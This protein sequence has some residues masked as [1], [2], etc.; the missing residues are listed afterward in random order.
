MAVSAHPSAELSSKARTAMRRP[1]GFVKRAG[2]IVYIVVLLEIV[3]P[4]LIVVFF[5]HLS[6]V[7]QFLVFERSHVPLP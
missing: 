4:N 1:S 3:Q 7:G 5:Y 6:S 2:N